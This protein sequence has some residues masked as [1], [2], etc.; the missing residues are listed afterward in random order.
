[1]LIFSLGEQSLTGVFPKSLDEKI[2][3][4]PVDLLK[5]SECGLVQLKQSYSLSEMYGENYGYRSG[6]NQSMIDHLSLKIKNVLA[7]VKLDEGDA[8]IDIGSNDGTT[9][10]LYEYGKYNL[11]GIDPTAKKFIDFYR[12]D[13][14]ILS[15]FFSVELMEDN[16]IVRQK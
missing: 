6:L 16:S 8:I 10:S 7:I 12:D 11:Y 3:K 2:S 1:M 9:L 4:G 5:C 15:D 13:I 14:N